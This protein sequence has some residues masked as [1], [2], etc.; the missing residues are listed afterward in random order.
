MYVLARTSDLDAVIEKWWLMGRAVLR[1]APSSTQENLIAMK[2][3][4]F[5]V[6][7]EQRVLDDLQL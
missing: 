1:R 6:H 7:V 3:K 2:T 5:H 4:P